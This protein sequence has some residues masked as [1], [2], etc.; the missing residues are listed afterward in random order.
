MHRCICTDIYAH[1]CTHTHTHTLQPR[2]SA[3]GT[4]EQPVARHGQQPLQHGLTRCGAV[5]KTETPEDASHALGQPNLQCSRSPV[6]KE[7]LPLT[8]EANLHRE[9]WI[10]KLHA[11]GNG[12]LFQTQSLCA[13]SLTSGSAQLHCTC[14]HPP[15]LQL[16]SVNEFA[17][18]LA[19]AAT[20]LSCRRRCA[21]APSARVAVH[22]DHEEDAHDLRVA[23]PGA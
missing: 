19:A 10:R 7:A 15:C 11:S 2:G 1:A 18:N 14:A 12:E 4:I 20:T 17:A 5:G 16:R 3:G 23:V 21:R 22:G 9:T 8:F 13:R 6:A